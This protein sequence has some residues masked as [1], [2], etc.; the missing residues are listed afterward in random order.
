MTPTQQTQAESH[1]G[2]RVSVVS[3]AAIGEHGGICLD[4]LHL[5]ARDSGRAQASEAGRQ[6]PG[7]RVMGQES[8]PLWGGSSKACRVLPPLCHLSCS[9]GWAEGENRAGLQ[10]LTRNKMLLPQY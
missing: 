2:S 10:R 1:R 8:Q 7:L 6:S 9:P 3:G 4:D 5:S